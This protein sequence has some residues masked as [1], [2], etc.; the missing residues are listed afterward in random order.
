[1]SRVRTFS[2]LCGVAVALLALTGGCDKPTIG[3]IKRTQ[4]TYRQQLANAKLAYEARDSLA[5]VNAVLMAQRAEISMREDAETL[6]ERGELFPD[7]AL[8][9]MAFPGGDGLIGALTNML[10]HQV[11]SDWEATCRANHRELWL[12]VMYGR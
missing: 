1:M 11:D 4:Q 10:P 8:E 9:Y 12:H 3:S 2:L 5:Y 6:L 7:E